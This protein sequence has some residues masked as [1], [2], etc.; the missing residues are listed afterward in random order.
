M[1]TLIAIKTSRRGC[2]VAVFVGRDLEFVEHRVL[3][4]DVEKAKE[5]V[6]AFL[7]WTLATFPTT[8]VAL[9][10]FAENIEIRASVLG[11]CALLSLRN[12]LLSVREV[13]SSELFEAY[14]LPPLRSRA[15]LRL[16]CSSFWP[17]IATRK[18]SPFALDV[19]ALGFYAQVEQ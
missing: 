12:S 7:A 13:R 17:Q 16:V 5:T 11:K 1:T 6:T 2:T 18:L 10:S 19:A 9:E 3:A 4:A 14:S 15:Q 8:S